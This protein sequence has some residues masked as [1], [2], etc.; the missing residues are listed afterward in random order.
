MICVKTSILYYDIN[1]QAHTAEY[2]FLMCFSPVN[3]VQ[4]NESFIRRSEIPKGGRRGRKEKKRIY[5]YNK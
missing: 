2:V 4:V 1:T 5:V 3:H